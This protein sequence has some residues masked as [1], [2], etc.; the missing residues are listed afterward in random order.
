M[1]ILQGDCH[2]STEEKGIEQLQRMLNLG[3]E[4]LITPPNVRYT[5]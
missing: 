3:N 5:S 1:I 2:T 4:Q